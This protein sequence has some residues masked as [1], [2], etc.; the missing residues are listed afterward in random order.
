MQFWSIVCLISYFI[1]FDLFR[2]RPRFVLR[3][4]K[5]KVLTTFTLKSTNINCPI[6]P[7]TATPMISLRS[8]TERANNIQH[9]KF[10]QDSYNSIYFQIFFN[11]NF[12]SSC[13]DWCNP[14]PQWG[15]RCRLL[16]CMWKILPQLRHPKIVLV[17]II[18]S[19]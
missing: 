7:V 9:Q 18:L 4:I 17:G 3:F 15:Q 8:F 5:I 1:I 6:F 14:M 11:H 13:C 19:Y 10:S 2:N 16:K 12:D